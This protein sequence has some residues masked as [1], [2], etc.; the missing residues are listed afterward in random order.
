MAA[1]TELELLLRRAGCRR[2]AQRLCHLLFMRRQRLLKYCEQPL[3]QATWRHHMQLADAC[4]A[5]LETISI[6]Y[7]RYHNEAIDN[8]ES[9]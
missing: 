9:L 7:R 6:L 3:P 2:H 4:S 1:I 5:A 8:E